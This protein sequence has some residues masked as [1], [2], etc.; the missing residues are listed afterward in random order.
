MLS[1]RFEAA[2][3]TI[4]RSHT[5]RPPGPAIVHVLHIK[6]ILPE[7]TQ[8]VC[9]HMELQMR[10]NEWFFVKILFRLSIGN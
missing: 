4:D 8:L 1:V 2:V 3:P 5:A 10:Y 9:G 6:I 7:N